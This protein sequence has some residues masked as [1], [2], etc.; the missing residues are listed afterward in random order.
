M[1]VCSTEQLIIIDEVTAITCY[2]RIIP[3]SLEMKFEMK[4]WSNLRDLGIPN[5]LLKHFYRLQQV[6]SS[7]WITNPPPHTI[8]SNL[9]DQA[10]MKSYHFSFSHFRTLKTG[11]VKTKSSRTKPAEPSISRDEY[12][13]FPGH[14]IFPLIFSFHL[15]YWKFYIREYRRP[16]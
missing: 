13:S 11:V 8:V 1:E 3:V 12:H 10:I 2:H 4:R 9:T 6:L 7:C 14:I 15:R 5:P 16:L